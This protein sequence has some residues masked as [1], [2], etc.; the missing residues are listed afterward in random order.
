MA[1]V[2]SSSYHGHSWCCCFGVCVFAFDVERIFLVLY[3]PYLPFS[4]DSAADAATMHISTIG[5][6]AVQTP[7]VMS[8]MPTCMFRVSYE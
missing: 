6:R 3:L 2:A 7:G 4:L 5:A 8:Q 1:L